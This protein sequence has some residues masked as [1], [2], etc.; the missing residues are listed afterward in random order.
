MLVESP[1]GKDPL[2]KEM[3]AYS[4]IVGELHG[5][6]SVAG[7]SPWGRKRVGQD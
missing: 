2:E 3:A 7:Y 6:R 5:Q 4:S 1:G